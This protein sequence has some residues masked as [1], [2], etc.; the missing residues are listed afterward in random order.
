M[1]VCARFGVFAQYGAGAMNKRVPND[2]IRFCTGHVVI[3]QCGD[4]DTFREDGR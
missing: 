2:L 3:A 1:W 4:T